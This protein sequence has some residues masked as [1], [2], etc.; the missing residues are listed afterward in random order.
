M[1]DPI[2]I[3]LQENNEFSTVTNKG[4]VDELIQNDL[5]LFWYMCFRLI[6]RWQ[7]GYVLLQKNRNEMSLVIYSIIC[8]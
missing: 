3:I 5:Y 6:V 8:N 2:A 1:P 7:L 4:S